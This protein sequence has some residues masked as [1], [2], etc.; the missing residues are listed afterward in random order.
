MCKSTHVKLILNWYEIKGNHLIGEDN[1]HNMSSD[2]ILNLFNTPFWNELYHCWSVD[3]SKVET[4]QKNVSHKID[5]K[6]Y[7]YFVE[8]YNIS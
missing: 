4:L 3:K 2:D 8:I 5:V 7:S 6:K 1:I